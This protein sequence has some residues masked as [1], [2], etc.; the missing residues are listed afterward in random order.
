MLKQILQESIFIGLSLNLHLL[1]TIQLDLLI[2]DTA[3]KTP[4]SNQNA[5]LYLHWPLE[6]SSAQQEVLKWLAIVSM[7]FDHVNKLVFS[8]GY[9]AFSQFGRLAFPLFC[10]LIAYNLVK[11]KTAPQRYMLPL[12]IFGALSQPIYVWGFGADRFN[13]MFTLLLGV[14]YM[15]LVAWLKGR[16]RHAV[17]AHILTVCALAAPATF[18]S[19]DL[20]GPFLIPILA[21][22]LSRPNLF[23]VPGIAVYLMLTNDFLPISVYTLLL[24]P[25]VFIIPKLPVRLGRTSKWLFYTFYPLHILALASLERFVL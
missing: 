1:T 14:L 7:T 18:V 2:M 24:L 10:Y 16:C 12:L 19:Y 11:R 20:F 6:L 4:K 5:L 3:N 13:I 23:W 25:V 22:F 21:G 15:W 8:G 9:P 17:V